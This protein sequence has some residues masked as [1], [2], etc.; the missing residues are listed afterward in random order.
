MIMVHLMLTRNMRLQVGMLAVTGVSGI[1][2][3]QIGLVLTY[4]SKLF[5]NI[6]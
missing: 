5:E 4:T 1:S 2:A 6:V 3:A